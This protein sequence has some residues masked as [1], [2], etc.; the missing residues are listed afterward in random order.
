M[1]KKLKSLFFKFEE[2]Q[3]LK[4]LN[5]KVDSLNEDVIEI[6]EDLAKIKALLIKICQKHNIEI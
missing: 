2:S 3:K 4:V 5:A 1:F 6:N